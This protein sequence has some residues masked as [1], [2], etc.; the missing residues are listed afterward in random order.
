[1]GIVESF[2]LELKNVWKRFFVLQ[3][4]SGRY[5]HYTSHNGLRGILTDGGLRASYRMTM[6]DNEEFTY[7]RKI[8]F[9]EL[10]AVMS[11]NQWSNFSKSVVERAK[12]LLNTYLDDSKANPRAY[13]ACLSTESDHPTQWKNYAENGRGFAIGFDLAKL[14]DEWTGKKGRGEPYISFAPV[15]YDERAQREF[16]QSLVKAGRRD[17][18]RF[19]KEGFTQTLLVI[20]IASQLMN[21]IDF[22]KDP[23]Y[24]SE[25]EI[26]LTL[27][28]KDKGER[29]LPQDIKYYQRGEEFIPYIF[30]DLR[31]SSTGLIPIAEIKIGP[32]ADLASARRFVGDLIFDLGYCNRN[33][34]WPEITSS[35]AII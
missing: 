24:A 2:P 31:D 26:R 16:I 14:I 34:D 22:I 3:N 8:I 12:C 4:A 30:L 10:D 18:L 32:N 25:H 28:Y 33:V 15:L 1:M 19:R 7:A 17:F 5:Y 20:K 9:E 13:C 27:E 11:G 29:L 23:F 6:S 21:L 35:S